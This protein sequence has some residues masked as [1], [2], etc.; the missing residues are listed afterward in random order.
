LR[1]LSK[2]R[3]FLSEDGEVFP[4]TLLMHSTDLLFRFFGIGLTSQYF[5][6][7]K[8]RE[9]PRLI[10]TTKGSHRGYLRPWKILV[11]GYECHTAW[12]YFRMSL[13]QPKKNARNLLIIH[14]KKLAERYVRNWQEHERHSEVYVGRER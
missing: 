9:P 1:L 4:R 13:R 8:N 7:F 11:S 5:S 6:K 14:D 10:L 3:K 12:S 2:F